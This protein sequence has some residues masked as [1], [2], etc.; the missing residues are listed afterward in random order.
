MPHDEGRLAIETARGIGEH[1]L[2]TATV[3]PGNAAY[4]N[5]KIS[6][7]RLDPVEQ[8][9]DQVGPFGRGLEFDPFDYA[10]Q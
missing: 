2:A 8:T 10:G 6:E 4:R 7:L 1:E 3:T 5:G 9:V